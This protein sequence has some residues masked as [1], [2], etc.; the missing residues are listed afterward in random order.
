MDSEPDNERT[1]SLRHSDYPEIKLFKTA[2]QELDYIAYKIQEL[3]KEGVKLNS[4]CLVTRTKSA[5]A[6]Y[7]SGLTKKGLMVYE[8][9]RNKPDDLKSEGVRMA[10]MHRVK[11]LDFKYMFVASANNHLIPLDAAIDNT[12]R[13]TKEET[14]M[15]EKCLLYVALTRASQKAFVSSYGKMSEFLTNLKP[16]PLRPLPAPQDSK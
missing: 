12:D 15:A 7:T 10:T 16:E 9:K 13:V 1:Q 2:N 5:L 14:L 6:G 3:S 4:I 8:I 11:G